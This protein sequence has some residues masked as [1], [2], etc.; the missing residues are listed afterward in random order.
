MKKIILAIMAFT[1]VINAQAQTLLKL[2][3]E[4]NKVYKFKSVVEQSVS[5]TVNGMTQN[6][7]TNSTTYVSIKALEITPEFLVAEVR[8]DSI[9]SKSNAMGRN[10]LVS[11]S[12]EGNMASD[13]AS[14]VLSAVMNRISKNPLFVKLD[15]S[16]KVREIVNYNMISG[17]VLKDTAQIKGLAAQ[18]LKEQAVNTASKDAL[19]LMVESFTYNVPNKEVKAGDKWQHMIPVNSGGMELEIKSDYKLSKLAANDAQIESENSIKP[20]LDAKPMNYG[21]ANIT[22]DNLSG[23]GKGNMTIDTKTGWPKTSASK[24]HITGDLSLSVQ[25]MNMT[26]PMIIDSETTV[27]S[28]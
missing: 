26:I 5:Q 3:P 24:M 14:E 20:A 21:G 1:V 9:I 17:I 28:L 8:F 15:F 12:K 27:S 22:Y 10:I 23:L 2:N 11:S 13:D 25:G 16:G 7:T 4:K 6:T 19:N 18:A